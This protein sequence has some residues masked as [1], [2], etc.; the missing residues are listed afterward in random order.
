MD[1][2]GILKKTALFGG[3]SD[4]ELADVLTTAR[5]RAF[6]AGATMVHE[7]DPGAR[8]FYLILEGSADVVRE[9]TRVAQLG[10]GEYF[11]EMALL[12]DDTSRTA[13][14]VATAPTTCLVITQWD[15]RAMLRSHPDMSASI[16]LE[17]A[18]R[19]RDS[20]KGLS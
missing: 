15:F 20:G 2:T 14:V 1:T 7:G 13:D 18:Q 16:M 8:G 11:G 19:L 5:Q 4:K 3:L 9:G 10:P 12:L 6:D 17:L